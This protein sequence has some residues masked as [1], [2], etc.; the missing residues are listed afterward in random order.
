MSDPSDAGNRERVETPRRRRRGPGMIDQPGALV[1]QVTLPWPDKMLFPN[2][3]KGR[4]WRVVQ[5]P[6]NRQRHTAEMLTSQATGGPICCER[7]SLHVAFAPPDRR[8]RDR[9][10]CVAALKGAQDGIADAIGIDDSTF[11]VSYEIV[12]PVKGGAVLV[13]IREVTT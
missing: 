8:R 3:S 11:L 1:F 12:P 6:R 2:N 7:V 10:N 5:K 13:T 4:H 9:D